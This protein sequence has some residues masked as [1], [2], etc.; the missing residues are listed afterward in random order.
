MAPLERFVPIRAVVTPEELRAEDG[1]PEATP[2]E[3]VL[4]EVTHIPG[5]VPGRTRYVVGTREFLVEPGGR[6]PDQMVLFLLLNELRLRLL[7]LSFGAPR[8]R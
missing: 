6:V 8:R 1:G 7:G 3:L 4:P 2:P 5:P